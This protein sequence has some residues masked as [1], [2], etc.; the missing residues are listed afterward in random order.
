MMVFSLQ[1]LFFSLA[2]MFTTI[3]G[4]ENP[5]SASNGTLMF[6]EPVSSRKSASSVDEKGY[7]VLFSPSPTFKTVSMDVGVNRGKVIVGDWLSAVPHMYVIGVEANHHL[8]AHFEYNEATK[9]YRNRALIFPV[10]VSTKPGIATFNTGK[11][12]ILKHLHRFL[13]HLKVCCCLFVRW[14][15][16]G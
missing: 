15:L 5:F 7:L 14:R 11:S 9:P 8:A 3:V 13:S 6:T 4:H 2:T 10:A 12:P 1:I 16:G